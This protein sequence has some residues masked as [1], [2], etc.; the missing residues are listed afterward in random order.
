[1]RKKDLNYSFSKVP[2]IKKPRSRFNRSHNHIT[3]FDSGYLVPV[4]VDEVL[5]GDTFKM[6]LSSFSRLATPAVPVMDNVYMD[7]H[8]FYVPNRLLWEH[9]EQM[10]GQQDKPGAKI[11]YLTPIFD[12]GSKG[13]AVGSLFDYMGVPP[14]VPHLQFSSLFARAYNKIWND[15]YR[16]ENL[17]DPVPEHMDDKTIELGDTTS[18]D[19]VLLRRN[20]KRDYF[21]GALPWPQKGP[22]AALNFASNSDI[23]SEQVFASYSSKDVS[24]SK[25]RLVF[26]SLGYGPTY[27]GQHQS[28]M[29]LLSL[30]HTTGRPIKLDLKNSNI[31]LP[32]V[33]I[34]QLRQA[35]QLQRLFE[36]DAR[37]GTRYIEMIQTHFGV[38]VPD[39]RLQRSEYLGGGKSIIDFNA[40]PQ[41]SAT[42]GTSPQGN[43]AAYATQFAKNIGFTRSFD[44]HGVILCLAS[45]RVDQK[46]QYGLPRMYSRRTRLDYYMPVNANLGEQAIMAKELYATGDKAKDELVF[47]YQERWSEYRY[48]PNR[49]SGKLRSVADAPLDV[50]H[51]GQKFTEPP[52]LNAEFIKSDPP[53]KRMLAVQNEPQIVSDLYFQ[54]DCTRV[55]PVYSVPGSFGRF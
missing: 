40:I 54:V 39:F 8:F 50:W 27:N 15:W 24:V 7:F 37:G 53:L 21:T 45:V 41:T 3:A 29:P 16:D 38:T 14:K 9:W 11:D 33:S 30:D 6:K 36:L 22:S 10:N 32:P 28:F 18:K 4:Y 35:V 46:Y 49:V 44:E 31:S 19:Y 51:L 25:D 13:V 1:M 43:L 42:S 2:S 5:P 20:K 47:G 34:N 55:M 26:D 12:A 23:S 17:Q 52:K 48:N